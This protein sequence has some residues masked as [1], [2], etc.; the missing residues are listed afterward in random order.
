[1]FYSGLTLTNFCGAA[2]FLWICFIKE[3]SGEYAGKP[4]A[5]NIFISLVIPFTFLI[6]YFGIA[7]II[8]SVS[9]AL[10]YQLF[11]FLGTTILFYISLVLYERSFKLNN[12]LLISYISVV[13]IG[14]ILTGILCSI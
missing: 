14:A 10:F 2:S 6:A 7:S 13:A 1:M 9:G 8:A 3:P 11:L 12:P 4:G 5:R